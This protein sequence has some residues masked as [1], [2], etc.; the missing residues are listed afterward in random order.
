[1][2]PM[3]M[4]VIL[5]RVVTKNSDPSFD[6]PA[7]ND[8][9][10]LFGIGLIFFAADYFYIGAYTNGGDLA[11]VTCIVA[12]LPVVASVFKFAWTQS[13]PNAYQASGFVLAFIAVLLVSKGSA[14]N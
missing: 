11:T 6:F 7:G 9:L 3:L 2:V 8:L 14:T 1:M 10:I 13:L 5:G 12:L 4:L